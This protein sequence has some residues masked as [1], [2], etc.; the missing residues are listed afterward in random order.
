MVDQAFGS[1][2]ANQLAE[3]EAVYRIAPVG[4]AF[5]DADHRY[6]RINSRMAAMNGLPVE[7]HY[8]RTP[9]EL[10]PSLGPAIESLLVQV[11]T[12]GVPIRGLE[13]RAEAPG[14][15]GRMR[16]WL[17]N[18]DPVIDAAGAVIGVT[19]AVAEITPLK[20]AEAAHRAALI[21]ANR[22][23]DEFLATISH[24]F[25]T[26]LNAIHGYIRLLNM[27]I[28]GPMTEGQ[29]DTLARADRAS[30]HLLSLVNGLLDLAQLQAGRIEYAIAPVPLTEVVS[31]LEALITPSIQDKGLTFTIDVGADSVVLADRG[32]LVQV[33]LNLVSNAVKFTPVAG[34]ITIARI[35]ETDGDVDPALLNLSVQDTGA[36]IEQHDLDRIFEPFVQVDQGIPGAGLG[37]A[38]SRKLIRGMGGD[39]CVRSTPGKGST[40]IVA[41]PRAFPS[42][43]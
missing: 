11:L 20:E 13:F 31:E 12:T 24:E 17:L 33:L 3:L 37:L 39:I 41:L 22:T 23:K 1:S 16:D 10:M 2:V 8:G 18:Y 7:A 25:R 21:A 30:G 26:P 34:V 43:S 4:L 29:R 5:L 9:T 6:V 15:P 32:K 38:I 36:G 42:A 28:H 35:P 27:G 40:F 14:E 19:A